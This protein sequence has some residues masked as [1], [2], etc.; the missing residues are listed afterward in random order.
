MNPCEGSLV[1][2]MG[3]TLLQFLTVCLNRPNAIHRPKGFMSA[4]D[5]WHNS[6]TALCT[7]QAHANNED[8]FST[9]TALA[10]T[11]ARALA[12]C[13]RSGADCVCADIGSGF[14]ANL[15]DMIG[16]LHFHH[17]VSSQWHAYEPDAEIVELI[18]AK[19]LRLTS[20]TET[21]SGLFSITS[22]LED[23]F[24]MLRHRCTVV[25]LIH[26][27]YYHEDA[28]ALVRR[29]FDD[30][31]IPG[32]SVVILQ[33]AEDSPFHVLDDCR[34]RNGTYAIASAFP[35]VTIEDRTMRFRFPP[36]TIRNSCFQREMF[37]LMLRGYPPISRLDDF[38]EQFE[39][40]F[41]DNRVVDLHDQIVTIRNE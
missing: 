31:L 1:L 41:G 24:G 40:V 8:W 17:H 33:L 2:T 10:A 25:T 29:C 15:R 26:S 14:C 11:V 12:R 23:F 19:T 39:R 27:I 22:R 36:A 30:L 3:S 5:F 18:R 20:G 37:S 32:G 34:P 9:Q 13:C 28:P 35:D 7:F 38:A 16:L 4:F 6:G 21:L